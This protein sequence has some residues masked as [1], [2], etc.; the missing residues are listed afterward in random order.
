LAGEALKIQFFHS[1]VF[2]IAC[3]R[4]DGLFERSQRLSEL[5][6]ARQI[7]RTFRPSQKAHVFKVLFR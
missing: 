1:A 2:F 4:Q 6:T 7:E 3:G 5:L